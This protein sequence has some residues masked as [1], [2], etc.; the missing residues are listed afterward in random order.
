MLSFLSE[1]AAGIGRRKRSAVLLQRAAVCLE[2]PVFLTSQASLFF[3]SGVIC[4][5]YVFIIF[6]L[7]SGHD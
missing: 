1:A 3:R 4:S 7:C 2:T 6:A 5:W